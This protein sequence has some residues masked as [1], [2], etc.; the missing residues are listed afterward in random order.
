M[1]AQQGLIP[2]VQPVPLQSYTQRFRGQIKSYSA[3]NGYGFIEGA[4]I[5]HAIGNN[6]YLNKREVCI[7]TGGIDGISLPKGTI[8]SFVVHYGPTGQPQAREVQFED[9]EWLARI[10]QVAMENPEQFFSAINNSANAQAIQNITLTS[11]ILSAEAL[12]AV[13]TQK[14]LRGFINKFINTNYVFIK[15]EEVHAMF[16]A[17]VFLG[18]NHLRLAMGENQ[19][20]LDKRTWV[21]FT[22]VLSKQGKLQAENVMIEDEV[23]MAAMG[24]GMKVP[25]ADMSGFNMSRAQ[26][27]VAPFSNP[28]FV[29]MSA[30]FPHMSKSKMSEAEAIASVQ[31]DI[32]RF[33]QQFGGSGDAGD[34]EE[35]LKRSRPKRERIRS[36]SPRREEPNAP[37]AVT[38][39]FQFEISQLNAQLADS[40]SYAQ[41]SNAHP[42]VEQ[43]NSELTRK[44][45]AANYE[46]KM[47]DFASA[48]IQEIE[49]QAARERAEK[50]KAEKEQAEK[51]Q[52]VKAQAESFDQ[53]YTAPQSQPPPPP[54]DSMNLDGQRYDQGYSAPQ[55]QSQQFG[56]TNANDQGYSAPQSQPPQAGYTDANE[57]R[58]DQGY[59]APQSQPQ[60]AGYTNANEQRY[61]QGYSAP[62]SQPQQAGYTNANEQRYE[63]GYSTQKSSISKSDANAN[64]A[65]AYAMLEEDF[66]R[67]TQQPRTQQACSPTVS[68]NENVDGGS[69][70]E[71][72][73]V[74]NNKRKQV[75]LPAHSTVRD[76]IDRFGK[77]VLGNGCVVT[78]N[79]EVM[80]DRMKVS[81]LCVGAP[82]WRVYLEKREFI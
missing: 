31:A 53:G 64:D 43:I 51:E 9:E 56:Y 46:Q 45:P 44:D 17:D 33:R 74:A 60:Q 12:N 35:D 38:D 27:E 71:V 52:A 13:H 11:A 82:P 20:I 39:A 63:Q 58:Y 30:N 41:Q 28:N 14:R 32:D 65:N 61:D 19:R 75:R 6:V 18:A 55:S 67:K 22:V 72:E 5:L 50:E 21:T 7:A 78:H 16:G 68:P 24:G 48:R 77:R 25:P 66:N 81:D 73:L 69:T 36:R 54:P 47:E 59:S 26:A 4:E 62:Q 3:E 79:K 76:V 2:Q 8:L 42:I 29:P 49:K 37:A 57:Q 10:K 40:S 70:I 80:N 23:G 34:G 15:G 1:L